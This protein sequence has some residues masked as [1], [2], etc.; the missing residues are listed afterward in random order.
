MMGF[1][2]PSYPSTIVISSNVPVSGATTTAWFDER[3]SNW[4]SYTIVIEADGYDEPKAASIFD[5]VEPMWRRRWRLSLEAIDRYRR[6]ARKVRLRG[7]SQWRRVLYVVR[8]CAQSER[9]R[10][11]AS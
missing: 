10:V 1:A 2:T 9:W 8:V 7:A 3:Q 4:P 5:G 11:L 6:A